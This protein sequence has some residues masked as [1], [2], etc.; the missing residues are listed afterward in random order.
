MQ[1]FETFYTV[2]ESN[3]QEELITCH[4]NKAEEIVYA[5]VSEKLVDY[6]HDSI[7]DSGFSNHIEKKFINMSEYK[8]GRVVIN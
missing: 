7:V 8:G 2:E 6:E 1:D 3:Q 5:T 4:F